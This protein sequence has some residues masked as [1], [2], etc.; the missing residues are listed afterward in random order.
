ML[1]RR[2][3]R[4]RLVLLSSVFS[5]T[6]L[7]AFVGSAL[8]QEHNLTEPTRSTGVL[9]TVDPKLLLETNGIVLSPA[10][11][12]EAA[13]SSDVARGV[14]SNIHPNYTFREVSLVR[15]QGPIFGDGASCLCWVVSLLP[16]GGELERVGAPGVIFGRLEDPYFLTFVD[17]AT[18]N[19]LFS[20]QGGR[21]VEPNRVDPSFELQPAKTPSGEPPEPAPKLR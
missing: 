1:Q 2:T 7:T 6:M 5:A 17:A 13:V 9:Q 19:L 11:T 4:T 20:A 21:Q 10:I 8:P 18:G 16:P 14:A 15:A 3:Q 12:A